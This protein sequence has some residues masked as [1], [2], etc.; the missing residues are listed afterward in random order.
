MSN[1]KIETMFLLLSI[2]FAGFLFFF[3]KLKLILLTYLESYLPKLFLYV[4]I[5]SL[6]SED[7]FLGNQTE[8]C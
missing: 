7:D 3:S 2:H 4:L 5:P 6:K 8:K 1:R